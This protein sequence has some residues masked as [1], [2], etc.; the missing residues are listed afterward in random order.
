M[1]FVGYPEEK[2]SW[3][4]LRIRFEDNIEMDLRL[5]SLR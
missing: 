4:R 2:I 5:L 3:G 1:V